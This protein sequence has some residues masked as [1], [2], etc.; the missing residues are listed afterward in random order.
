M[1]EVL[2]Q[3]REGIDIIIA[4]KNG[5]V[6]KEDKQNYMGKKNKVFRLEDLPEEERPSN[7]EFSIKEIHNKNLWQLWF[8]NKDDL[9]K[10]M[11]SNNKN[12]KI[13]VYKKEISKFLKDINEIKKQNGGNE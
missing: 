11:K 6:Y 12:E 9:K 5:L 1:N 4:D 3:I 7:W 13:A 10:I 8:E 2:M